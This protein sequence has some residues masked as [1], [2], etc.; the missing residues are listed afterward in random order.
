MAAG[1]QNLGPR[2]LRGPL[3]GRQAKALSAV[4]CEE[5]GGGGAYG[6][7]RARGRGLKERGGKKPT[8]P[9]ISRRSPI[10]VITSPD[11]ASF[12]RSDEISRIKGGMAIDGGGCSPKEP[13]A[14][15]PF[16]SDLPA[17]QAS[18]PHLSTGRTLYLSCTTCDRN[19]AC[20]S[21]QPGGR[22]MPPRCATPPPPVSI[23]LA[24]SAGWRASW[25]PSGWLGV[26]TCVGWG[27]G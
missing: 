27:M 19:P 7:S 10:H 12:S 8:A 9:G 6:G 23:R 5:P 14:V 4:G 16:C 15:S 3:A 26:R 11:P 22:P 13:C 25:T 18:W 17:D 21:R 1:T 2:C 20:Q 24:W